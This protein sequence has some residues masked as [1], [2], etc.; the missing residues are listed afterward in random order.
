MATWRTLASL[1]AA[2]A[3]TAAARAQTYPLKEEPLAGTYT[4]VKLSM[5]L[6]GEMKVQQEG[7][8]QILKE[9]ATAAHEY[10][11]RVLV[12]GAD[13]VA[14][15]T[16]RSYKN[17]HV[18]ITVGTGTSERTLRNER[19]YLVNQR[20]KDVVVTYCPQGTL[21]REELQLTEHFDTLAVTG[22]L[23][24]RAVAAGETW[25]PA[26][27]VAQALCHFEGLTAQEL[28]CKLEQ[29]KD[30]VAVIAVTG[31][32]AGIDLGAPV[33]VTV[34]ATA[35]F[36]LKAHRLTAVEW[37]QTDERGQ[38]PVSPASKVE[39]TTTMAR[40]AI[41]PEAAPEVG[42]LTLPP[43][44]AEPP[45][46]LT[47][48]SYRDPRGHYAMQ[49]ARE[50]QLAGRT[51]QH[52]VLRLM[53]RG[54]FVAQATLTPLQKT[55]PGKH[56]TGDEFRD[57]MAETPGWVQE[58]VLEAEEVKAP[59]N[60]NWIY[61]V[62]AEGEMLGVKALQYFYLVAGPQG[63]QLLVAFTLAPAQAQKL[64]TRDL[65]LLRGLAFPAA[66]ADERK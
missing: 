5:A 54:E 62:A 53:D 32:A 10:V 49:H 15:K 6:A 46:A 1:V 38:G 4:H 45:D 18:A 9:S 52:L 23:P 44:P 16:V 65:V 28:V 35:R 7:K 17:A 55:E 25:K 56:L 2:L 60:G 3:V 31:T 66:A 61:R 63:D 19:R 37:K 21:T 40:A 64:D 22:L 24:G 59:T 39:I 50:W 33:K 12:D 8:E 34:S 20:V 42:D 14:D 26:N 41:E 57:L 29:V 43:V 51:D 47:L 27:P 11:E 48:L 13:G 30:D 58:R 36:D